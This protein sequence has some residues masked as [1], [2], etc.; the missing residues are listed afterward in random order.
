MTSSDILVTGE[1]VYVKLEYFRLLLHYQR[2]QSYSNVG[3]ISQSKMSGFVDVFFVIQSKH[4]KNVLNMHEVNTSYCVIHV[5]LNEALLCIL[6]YWY[7]YPSHGIE[8]FISFN[9]FATS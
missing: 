4:W 8:N 1:Y 9:L 7:F 6:E 5:Y 3:Q 2:I